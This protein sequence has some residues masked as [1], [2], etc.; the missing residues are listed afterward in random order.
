MTGFDTEDEL[1]DFYN[2][3][4][5]YVIAGVVFVS[6]TEKTPLSTLDYKLRLPTYWGD[7]FTESTYQLIGDGGLRS[8]G[9]S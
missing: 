3:N 5:D 4:S 2:S 1:L 9:P 7:W 8:G 6:D